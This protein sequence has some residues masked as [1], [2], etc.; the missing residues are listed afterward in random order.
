MAITRVQA[1]PLATV[2]G[3]TSSTSTFASPPAVGNLLVVPLFDYN[4]VAFADG[5]ATDNYGNEWKLAV[6]SDAN[7]SARVAVLYCNVLTTGASFAVTINPA[8]AAGWYADWKAIEF[9]DPGSL[10]WWQVDKTTKATGSSTAPATGSTAAT[11]YADSVVIAAMATNQG[12]PVSITVETVSPA[13]TQEAE[14]LTSARQPGESDSKIITATGAQSCAWTLGASLAW[15]AAIVVFNSQTTPPPV[16]VRITQSYVESVTKPNP[17]IQLTQ[18][19]TEAIFTAPAPGIYTTIHYL[20]VI[21]SSAASPPAVTR[22][23]VWIT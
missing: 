22:T 3:G 10:G 15:S 9:N 13:W 18:S 23:E 20:E 12:S 11:T 14:W 4:A 1:S 17:N 5:D 16:S 8:S 19:Y 7:G 2:A 21:M 6:L